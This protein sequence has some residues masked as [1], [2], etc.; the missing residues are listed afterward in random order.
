[1][2]PEPTMASVRPWSASKTYELEAGR[3]ADQEGRRSEVT[4]MFI[5][6]KV[7]EDLGI[8]S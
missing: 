6:S 4:V 8:R 3:G 5:C 1:M 2:E 7:S